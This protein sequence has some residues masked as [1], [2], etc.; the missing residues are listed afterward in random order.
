MMKKLLL[1]FLLLPLPA[2]AYVRE[3][4]N[5]DPEHGWECIY[6]H[7]D[8]QHNGMLYRVGWGTGNPR[9]SKKDSIKYLDSLAYEAEHPNEQKIAEREQE[10]KGLL[11]NEKLKNNQ[12]AYKELDKAKVTN[13]EQNSIEPSLLKWKSTLQIHKE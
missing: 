10:E 1:L 7:L 11:F 4:C 2:H 3:S 9:M 12:Y 8:L 6:S 5:L 13:K